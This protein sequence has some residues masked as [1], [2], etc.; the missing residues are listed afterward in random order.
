MREVSC[1]ALGGYKDYAIRQG[2]DWRE[3][4]SGLRVSPEHL[5]NLREWFD[6]EDFAEI[7]HRMKQVLGPDACYEAG[8]SGVN[9]ELTAPLRRVAR[10]TVDL[11]SLYRFGVVWLTPLLIR[12]MRCQLEVI[13]RRHLRMRMALPHHFCE[14]PGFFEATQG[15]AEALPSMLGFPPA[16]VTPDISSRVG[17]YH[18]WLPV[19]H[20]GLLGRARMLVG[21]PVI[22]ELERQGQVVGEID[23]ERS[24]VER[25][26]RER[27]RMLSNLLENLSGLVYRCRPGDLHF[28]YASPQ[29]EALVGWTPQE[30]VEGGRTLLSLV[31]DDDRERVKGELE[32][33]LSERQPCT[34]EYRLMRHDG[35]SRWVLDVARGVHE[36][37]RL[38]AVEGFVTDVT[39]QK[40]LEEELDRASRVE[41]VGRLAGG[42]AHDFNNML[43]VIVSLVELSQGELPPDHS[44]RENLEQIG[45]AAERAAGM[46]RQLLAFARRQPIAPRLVDLDTLVLDMDKLLQRTLMED[47]T[48]RYV[49]GTDLWSVRIDPGQFEQVLLNLAINARDAM[50][51]GGELTIETGNI[52]LEQPT[53]RLPGMPPG[54]YVLLRARDTGVGMDGETR[55]RIFEPFFTTKEIGKGTGLGLAS[56]HGIVS[57]AGGYIYVNTA[58]GRGTEFSIYLPRVEG[59]AIPVRKASPMPGVGHGE[60]I[61]LVEDHEAL[62]ELFFRALVEQGY[63][64]ERA[65][66]GAEALE[67]L[68]ASGVDLLVTD[69]VMPGTGGIALADAARARFPLLPVLFMSGYSESGP[70]SGRGLDVATGFLAKPFTPTTLAAEVR[71]LLDQSSSHTPRVTRDSDH[72]PGWGYN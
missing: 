9:T 50:P 33:A 54:S 34:T 2:A 58:P 56:T 49:H 64:V 10:A 26:L 41:S 37:G 8:A 21:G 17:V 52:V 65:H 6:W 29:S 66:S 4:V 53:S 48:L 18:V 68:D 20:H 36:A 27:D 55:R 47:V 43:T 13:D 30:L 61:L 51:E 59:E 35:S 12:H 40:R 38:V 44:V 15:A 63:V 60:K 14:N 42:V 57:Q 28:E 45:S 22:D 1:R 62:N 19:Q 67:M 69:V 24:Q 71:V 46:T 3:L 70:P 23:R 39:A 7:L 72:G 31:H 11:Q 25:T 16:Q 5:E 32:S